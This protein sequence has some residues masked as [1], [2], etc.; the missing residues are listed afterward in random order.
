MAALPMREQNA[1]RFMAI[2]ATLGVLGVAFNLNN[3]DATMPKVLACIG[4]ACLVWSIHR[5][6]RLGPDEAI[7]FE[8]LEP[9][10]APKKKKKKKKKAALDPAVP[11]PATDDSSDAS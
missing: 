1:R 2:A 10:P 5:F 3:E 6:G 4:V 11:S 8:P 9:E 7:V